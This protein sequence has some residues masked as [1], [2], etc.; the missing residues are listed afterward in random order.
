MRLSDAGLRQ[1]QTKALYPHHP[2]PPWLIED[3]TRDRSNR[4]L[5]AS[6][7]RMIMLFGANPS[8]EKPTGN[9]WISVPPLRI[10]PQPPP[11]MIDVHEPAWTDSSISK[12][13]HSL[14]EGRQI[15]LT[16]K[17]PCMHHQRCAH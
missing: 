15:V 14:Q 1:R 13:H 7:E 6:A 4:L 9:D 11:R 17:K 3:A 8:I 2:S 10:P 5:G 16:A 12:R